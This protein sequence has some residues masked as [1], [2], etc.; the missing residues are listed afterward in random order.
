MRV[1][2]VMQAAAEARKTI[3]VACCAS[4]SSTAFPA[5]ESFNAVSAVVLSLLPSQWHALCV[6]IL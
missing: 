4:V 5:S 2:P 1:R 6:E 3:S